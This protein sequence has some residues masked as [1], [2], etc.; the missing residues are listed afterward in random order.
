MGDK[1]ATGKVHLL[2]NIGKE[3]IHHIDFKRGEAVEPGVEV[4]HLVHDIF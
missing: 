2:D 4:V 3:G 1:I